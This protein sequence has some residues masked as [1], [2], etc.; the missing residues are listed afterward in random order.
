MIKDLPINERPRE[1]LINQG[2][3]K[4]SNTELLAILIKTGSKKKSA[5]EIASEIIQL[6]K[7]GINEL[8]NITVQELCKING[9]GEAKAA[10]IL[11]AVELAKRINMDYFLIKEKILSPEDVYFTVAQDMRCFKKEIFRV[12]FLDTKNKV[13][14]YEDISVGSLNASIVHPREVFNRAIKKSSAGIILI[15]NHPSGNSKPSDE[16]IKITKRLVK[17]GELLGIK[18]LDHVI[19]GNGEYFSMKEEKMI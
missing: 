11:S 9:I 12:V 16:D 4:L 19:I 18:V 15:H 6:M 8:N 13:I 14:N 3:D 10:Y 7:N 5:I 17:A 2:T 1:K